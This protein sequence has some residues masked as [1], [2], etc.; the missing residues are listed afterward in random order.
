MV[1]EAQ[2]NGCVREVLVIAAAL[3]IQDP[4]ERPLEHQQAADEKHARFGDPDSDFLAF[5]NLWR[6]LQEQQRELS[7]SQFRRLCRTEFLNYLRV[8]EWQDLDSQ[9]RQVVKT[10]GITLERR[11]R[12]TPTRVHTSLLAGLLSHIGLQRPGEA[13]VPRRPR[14]AVRHLPGLGAVPQDARAG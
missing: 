2:T 10:M 12:P 1:L 9:L 3:S 7:S 11:S 8:R 14:R 5:L 4:R 13:R 6:Y